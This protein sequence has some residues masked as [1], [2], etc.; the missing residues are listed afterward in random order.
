MAGG[1]V[2]KAGPATAEPSAT[3]TPINP[4]NRF[5]LKNNPGWGL[6]KPEA[7]EGEREMGED[8]GGEAK[9]EK[10]ANHIGDGRQHDGG[11]ERGVDPQRFQS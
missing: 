10:E 3:I 1:M 5:T 9:K 11:G 4:A 6:C 8:D 7:S 2:M